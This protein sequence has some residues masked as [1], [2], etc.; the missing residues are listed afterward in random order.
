MKMNEQDPITWSGRF[1]P[2]L[3][4]VHVYPRPFGDKLRISLGTGGNPDSSARAGELGLPIVYAIIG[5]QP[6]RFAPLVEL[7]R[8]MSKQAGHAPES[9]HVTMSAI[10][11]VA[12]KSQDAKD[13]FFPYWHQTMRYGAAARGW[14][15]PSRADYDHYTDGAQMVFAGSADEV[16]ERLI[17]VGTLTQA[18]RYVMHMDW[19]GVPHELVMRGIEL[20]GEKV[21]PQVNEAMGS[22]T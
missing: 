15:V 18:D 13:A 5:G 1:R 4:N 7:Y 6:E 9:Q 17:S 11:L 3:D 21:I 20:I 14:S 16:A 22:G 12:D 19:A 2:P 8:H 10:G